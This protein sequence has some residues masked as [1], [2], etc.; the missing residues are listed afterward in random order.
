M[1]TDLVS[2]FTID[3]DWLTGPVVDNDFIYHVPRNTIVN[4]VTINKMRDL[5][6]RGNTLSLT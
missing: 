2:T 6:L 1:E 5:N 3:P 4:Y